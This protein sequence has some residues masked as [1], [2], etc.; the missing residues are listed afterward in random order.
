MFVKKETAKVFFARVVLQC[1]YYAQLNL[2]SLQLDKQK[3][4]VD[5]R[6]N[7]KM[8]ATIF[9]EIKNGSLN[10]KFYRYGVEV[11]LI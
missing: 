3:S 8:F 5:K 9:R 2:M 4:Y 7:L 11:I 10:K 1:K 6:V